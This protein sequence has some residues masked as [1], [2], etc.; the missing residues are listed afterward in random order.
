[1]LTGLLP[2]SPWLE[3][4]IWSKWERR[5][6]KKL[7]NKKTALDLSLLTPLPPHLVLDRF[8]LYIIYIYTYYPNK[9]FCFPENNTDRNQYDF[10]ILWLRRDIH[11]LNPTVQS[12]GMQQ[13][14]PTTQIQQALPLHSMLARTLTERSSWWGSQ[15]HKSVDP[16]CQ[17]P[18]TC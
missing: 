10:G 15:S 8:Y 16:W 1:M 18:S 3:L 14:T 4:A 2:R 5:T 12:P 13:R 11:S 7:R 6:T 9:L 17:I